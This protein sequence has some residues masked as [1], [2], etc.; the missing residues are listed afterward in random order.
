MTTTLELLQLPPMS[1]CGR[2]IGTFL[3]FTQSIGSIHLSHYPLDFLYHCPFKNQTKVRVL[4]QFRL[5]LCV[6]S[7][8]QATIP[9][10]PLIKYRRLAKLHFLLGKY[11]KTNLSRRAAMLIHQFYIANFIFDFYYQPSSLGFA[12]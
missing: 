5:S 3:S 11:P 2:L 1:L 9:I 12:K 7:Y 4:L 8:A 6:C 10:N